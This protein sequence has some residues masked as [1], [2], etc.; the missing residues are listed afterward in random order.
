MAINTTWKIDIGTVAAPTDFTSRVLSMSIRQSV[1]VNVMGRGT[2]VITLL[3]KDGALTPGGGGTYSSTDWFAQGV[4]INALTDI[5]AGSTSTDV[6]DGIIT[7]FEL[8][9]NGVF[10]T[11]TLTAQDGL[12]VGGKSPLQD[13]KGVSGISRPYITWLSTNIKTTIAD[14][15]IYPLLGK[16]NSV[17]LVDYVNSSTTFD[18]ISNPT[19]SSVYADGWQVNIIPTANDVC[20]AT[21]IEEAVQAPYGAVA[22]YRV[23]AMPYDTTRNAANSV[24]FEF[25]PEGSI[26]GTKL[27]FSAN[28]FQQAFN[29]DTLINVAT[30][31]GQFATFTST[32]TNAL[33]YGQRTVSFNN[34]GVSDNTFAQSVAQRLTN[35]YSTPKFN[36]VELATSAKLVK[37][38]ADDSAESFWRNLLS[39]EKG[40]WQKT[41]I[42][43][44]GSGASAQTVTCVIKGRT[45]NVTP[46]NTDVSLFFGDWVDNHSFILDTD[47]LDIDRLG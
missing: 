5:G 21:I 38:K 26:T 47:K 9:D 34:T 41:T 6:F 33:T 35:R 17:G 45:I 28:N 30:V 2:C 4:F 46:E 22:R 13:L 29:I 3:N 43:W 36:V 20:Y 10:S 31:G 7:N 15:S 19:G 42:T 24:D 12:T 37:Q 39:I 18:N 1:D 32:S 44:T 16:P 14:T 25:A 40:L 11:V 8:Q 23:N 27:P